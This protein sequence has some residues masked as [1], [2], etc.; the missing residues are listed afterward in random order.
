M[1]SL[2]YSRRHAIRPLA[3]S[4][5]EEAAHEFRMLLVLALLLNL[6]AYFCFAAVRDTNRFPV[7]V[8]IARAKFE[9]VA[10]GVGVAEAF[11]IRIR[12][13]KAFIVL[14]AS[15]ITATNRRV[16]ALF[17]LVIL[18]LDTIA[19]FTIFI[20][21]ALSVDVSLAFRSKPRPPKTRVFISKSI[22]L[23]L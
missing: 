23:K 14:S 4:L 12:V 11:T 10:G 18:L 1:F 20:L 6:S 13:T 7:A 2:S 17:R 3:I 19:V 15:V 5:S 8:F 22:Y 9:L 21:L 16:V